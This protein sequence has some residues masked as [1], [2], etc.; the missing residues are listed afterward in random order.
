M[1][2]RCKAC[3]EI[4]CG[5]A[6]SGGVDGKSHMTPKER[7]LQ[8]YPNAVLWEWADGYCI[9]RH[10]TENPTGSLG[11][12][13]YATPQGAWYGAWLAVQ[14][15]RKATPILKKLLAFRVKASIVSIRSI[16]KLKP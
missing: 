11:E 7:V 8:A 13:G 5:P 1:S 6:C 15:E 16:F 4:G 14:D 12:S 9:Y 2:E 10:R 3:G